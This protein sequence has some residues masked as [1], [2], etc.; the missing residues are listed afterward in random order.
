MNDRQLKYAKDVQ[1][2]KDCMVRVSAAENGS[3]RLEKL[4]VVNTTIVQQVSFNDRYFKIFDV[5]DRV[6]VI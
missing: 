2:G 1:P 4:R 5:I 6:G 3:T